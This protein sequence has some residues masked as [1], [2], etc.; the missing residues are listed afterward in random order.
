MSTK[1]T[2]SE[3]YALSLYLIL[4]PLISLSFALFLPIS[5]VGIALLMLL[6]PSTLAIVLTAL[7]EGK[8]SLT[9]LLKKL[10]Q[11]RIG[12]KWYAVALGLPVGIILVSSVLAVLLGWAPSVQIS[13]PERSMLI[14]NSLFIPL[15]ALLE[16]LGW[17]GYALPRLLKY[18]SP[19][20]SALII[21]IA[22]GLLHIGLGLVD[23]RPWV[24]TFLS[25]FAMSIILTWLFMHTRGSLAMAILF[26]FAIDY[27]PQFFFTGLTPAQ[28]V[29]AQT[30]LNLAVA[31]VLILLFGANLQ[32]SPVNEPALADVGQAAK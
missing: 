14:V 28:G 7:A 4:T 12:L 3:G 9:D 19:L 22:W 30:I 29:W 24:P 25:P 15:V 27:A 23:G 16:E 5:V 6:I 32:R 26:H 21:G 10:F 17:R 13:V 2:L 18:R 1:S 20:A 8:K 31:F 11:W